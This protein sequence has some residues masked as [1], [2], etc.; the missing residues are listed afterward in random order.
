HADG[1]RRTERSRHWPPLAASGPL[2]R[3]AT[4][5]LD[6][7]LSQPT[8]QPVSL[9]RLD[10]GELGPV[11]HAQAPLFGDPIAARRNRLTAALTDQADRHGT[12]VLGRWRLEP[13]AEDG[14]TL[15][16]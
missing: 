15:E 7:A 3:V 2:E 1:T 14:W 8:P 13:L 10:A 5:L 9:L 12:S 6:H 11:L 16:D 4:A